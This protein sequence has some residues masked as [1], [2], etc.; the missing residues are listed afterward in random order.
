MISAFA[1]TA[2]ASNVVYI[3]SDI[4][5]IA[6]VY[7]KRSSEKTFS[8]RL[9]ELPCRLELESGSPVDIVIEQDFMFFMKRR[10]SAENISMPALYP[11]KMN[12][13]LVP[14]YPRVITLSLILVALAGFAAGRLIM[15]RK[16][17]RR[18]RYTIC[19]LIGDGAMASVYK[20]SDENGNLFALKVPDA[21][22]FKNKEFYDRFCHEARICSELDHKSIVRAF[23]FSLGDASK[24]FIAME[25]ING[26]GL[27]EEM[28]SSE[29]RDRIL[30]YSL[31][32]SEA[33]EYLHAHGIIHRDIKP[34]NIMITDDGHV[35]IADFGI[36]KA[37]DFTRLTATGAF[38]GT[39]AY[40]APEQIDGKNA[41]GRADLYSLGAIIYEA[42]SG[43]L[44]FEGTDP[45]RTAIKKLTEAPAPLEEES[46]RLKGLDKLAMRL[47]KTDPDE[48]YSSASEVVSELEKIIS[49]G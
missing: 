26:R 3:E 14:D 37:S 45:V 23:D 16:L 41:D 9:I 38:M 33:L 12:S 47:L 2:Y 35:K 25:L 36:S 17:R 7:V 22:G 1:G 42:L 18:G 27:D 8:K 46:G 5:G 10:A 40:M 48:R 30:A 34:S 43:R 28:A 21:K 6:C 31:E 13:A 4:R 29:I 39:P 20:A 32:I 24:A 15:K 11:V 19:S 49:G 44:P